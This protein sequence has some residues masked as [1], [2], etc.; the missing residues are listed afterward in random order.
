M[1]EQL[2]A[3]KQELAKIR[4]QCCSTS[5]AAVGVCSIEQATLVHD[6][7]KDN[8]LLEEPTYGGTPGNLMRSTS[9]LHSHMSKTR[10]RRFSMTS[11]S[12]KIL[13]QYLLPCGTYVIT[14]VV[15]L[16]ALLSIMT[17]RLCLAKL[18]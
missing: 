17:V 18:L 4:V 8:F 11:Q 16:L 9:R 10:A 14:V 3:I 7:I 6:F 12:R 13:I 1:L 15:Q 2:R 5:L